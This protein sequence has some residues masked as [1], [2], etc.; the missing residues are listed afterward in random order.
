MKISTTQ[1]NRRIG[2]VL[3]ALAR[4]EDVILTRYG[5]PVARIVS[6]AKT[7]IPSGVVF[8][9]T[10]GHEHVWMD[11]TVMGDLKQHWMCADCGQ[12]R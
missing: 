6:T 7:G 12:A 4:G 8:A 2:G 11:V 3:E 1:L 5:K 10:I 9:P